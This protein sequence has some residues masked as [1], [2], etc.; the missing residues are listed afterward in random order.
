L[1]IVKNIKLEKTLSK[2]GVCIYIGRF[3]KK[4]GSSVLSNPY[5]ITEDQD[6]DTVVE[7]YRLWL[8]KELKKKGE[9]YNE[10]LRIVKMVKK[11]EK[12]VLLCWCKPERC[13]GDIVKSC[14]LWMLKNDENNF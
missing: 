3:N 11:G 12:V 2:D 8:W 13:H 10:L 5:K 9:V 14:L 7:K 4:Y 1:I 6:R